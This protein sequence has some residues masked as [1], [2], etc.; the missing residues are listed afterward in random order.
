MS[1]STSSTKNKI[2]NPAKKFLKF[3]GSTGDFFYYD[4]EQEKDILIQ[5]PFKFIIIDELSTLT[6]YYDKLSSAIFSNEVHSTVKE[7][8]NLR[9]FKGGLLLNGLYADIKNK[10]SYYGAKYTKSIYIL[11]N[12]ELCNLQLKGAAL[13]AWINDLK[14]IVKYE[15]NLIS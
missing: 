10:L 15:V 6:G 7:P 3:K 9:A 1:I 4:K 13:S 5:T 2:S 8:L 11:F 12:D 14:K